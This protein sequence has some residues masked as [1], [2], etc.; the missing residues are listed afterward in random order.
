[1]AAAAEVKSGS[2]LHFL[3][4]RAARRAAGN[5]PP[6]IRALTASGAVLDLENKGEI[7]RI[8]R[9]RQTW[10]SQAWDYFDAIGEISYAH[11]FF[12]NCASRMRIFPA[13]YATGNFDED[14]VPLAD[15]PGIPPEVVAA[16][17]DAM[18]DLGSGRLAMASFMAATSFNLSVSGEGFILGITDPQTG[19]STFSVRSIDEIIV[20]E[21]KYQLREL[22]GGDTGGGTNGQ[23]LPVDS[24]YL[25]RIW[26]PHPRWRLFARSS[27]RAVLD[28]CEELQ[29]LNRVI[30]ST[31]RARAAQN[32]ILLVPDTI[33]AEGQVEDNEDPTSD[34]FMDKFTEAFILGI[35]DEGVASA[36]APVVLRGPAGALEQVR[37]L[38]TARLTR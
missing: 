16:A 37:H 24:T 35:A 4:N 2:S 8:R 23:D 10:Q 12:A 15:A 13:A 7:R 14:P 21:D 38:S 6:Q 33:S 22:P 29:I 36:A 27:M 18:N 1:M 20:N 31:G 25:A 32:G 19:V 9:M 26:T 3:R 34:P 30:R 28:V 11:Q 5:P 17:M